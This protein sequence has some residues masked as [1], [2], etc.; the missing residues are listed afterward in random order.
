MWLARQPAVADCSV[1]AAM[2]FSETQA[3]EA[4]ELLTQRALHAPNLLS[5][6]L[7]S[8]GLKKRLAGATAAEI[9]TAFAD[10]AEQRIELHPVPAAAAY[11]LAAQLELSSYDAAYLWLAAELNAPLL[12]FDRRLAQ[13]AARHLGNPR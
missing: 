9:D 8:V 12:T 7:A 11:E 5:Y 1:L 2:L 10:F 13:A 4:M 6:E 3:E